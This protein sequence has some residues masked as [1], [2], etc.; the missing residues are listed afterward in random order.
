VHGADASGHRRAVLAALRERPIRVAVGS[1]V[2]MTATPT[3]TAWRTAAASWTPVPTSR[4]IPGL[5]GEA[6][7]PADATPLRLAPDAVPA[8]LA[9]TVRWLPYVE[10]AS[11][12]YERT[13]GFNEAQWTRGQRQETVLDRWRLAE[14]A[15]LIRLRTAMTVTPPAEVGGL[16]L[17]DEGGEPSDRWLVV[18]PGGTHEGCSVPLQGLRDVLGGGDFIERYDRRIWWDFLLEPRALG[19][20]WAA[21]D[22]RIEAAQNLPTAWSLPVGQFHGCRRY[23]L[24][25]H[26]HKLAR[27]GYLCPDLGWIATA[28]AQYG[29]WFCMTDSEV[30]TRYHIPRW[31]T[32]P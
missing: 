26:D 3:P 12:T 27:S 32:I 30:L 22:W 19:D 18:L 21:S 7:L 28:N 1:P 17:R 2:P 13:V 14:D 20:D 31:H 23:R 10:G 5:Q 6:C 9:D 15:M 24:P 4:S 25:A 29:M 8:P 16:G 11:W